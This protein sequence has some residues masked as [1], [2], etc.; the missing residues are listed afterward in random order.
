MLIP[1]ILFCVSYELTES[2]AATNTTG[3]Q[4]RTLTIPSRS[5]AV[6][7]LVLGFI[8]LVFML[9]GHGDTGLETRA[10]GLRGLILRRFGDVFGYWFSV[11]VDWTRGH[12]SGDPRQRALV[13]ESLLLL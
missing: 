8:G 5:V 12:G 11:Y 9:I 6:M 7:Y 2:Q 1:A 10:S 13:G 4:S 3:P